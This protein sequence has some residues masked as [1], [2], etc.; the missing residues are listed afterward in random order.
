MKG[1]IKASVEGEEKRGER[2]A[3]DRRRREP[4]KAGSWRA[5][6]P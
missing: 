5:G 1:Q 3:G 6:R 4:G 2:K